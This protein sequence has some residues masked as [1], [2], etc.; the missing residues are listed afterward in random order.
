[1]STASAITDTQSFI[2]GLISGLWRPFTLHMIPSIIGN[3]CV[4]YNNF[5]IE[6]LNL[7]K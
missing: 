6:V 7:N 2:K 5:S 3:V 1:M 4:D